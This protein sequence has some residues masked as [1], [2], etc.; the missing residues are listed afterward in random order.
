MESTQFRKCVL[1]PYAIKLSMIFSIVS[2][3]KQWNNS[4]FKFTVYI[5][6]SQ[7]MQKRGRNNAGSESEKSETTVDE[8]KTETEEES[9][10]DAEFMA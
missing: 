9:N 2:E 4:N 3:Q 1:F 5:Q 8:W 7:E 10:S 6:K